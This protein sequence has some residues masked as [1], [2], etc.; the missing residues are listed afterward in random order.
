MTAEMTKPDLP[1]LVISQADRATYAFPPEPAA[2]TQSAGIEALEALAVTQPL[3][4]ADAELLVRRSDPHESTVH[5]FAAR[6][7]EQRVRLAIFALNGTAVFAAG[8]MLQIVLIRYAGMGHDLSYVIQTVVSVQVGFVLARFL[9]WRDRQVYLTVALVKYNLQMLAVTGLGIAGYAGLGRLGVNFIAANVGVTAVLTPVS[10]A[11]S[12]RW[13]LRARRKSPG[14]WTLVP[15]PLLLLLTVQA[16]LS[17]RLM[18]SNTAFSDEALYLWSGHLELTHLL[19]GVKVP[20]FQTY[21]S[22]APVIYPILGAIADS[23]GGL[24]GARLLSLCFMLGATALLYSTTRRLFSARAGA[25]AIAVFVA[26]GATQSLGAFATYDSMA[27]F[28]LALASW[29]TVRAQGWVSEPALLCSALVLAFADATKYATALWNPVVLALAVLTATRGGALRALSRGVRL[30]IYTAVSALVALYRLGGPTYIHG[31]MFTTVARQAGGT[32]ATWWTIVRN[33]SNWIGVLAILVGIAVC[34]SFTDTVRVRLLCAVLGGALFLAP[35]HQAQIHILTSLSKHIDFGAWF[36]A[37]AA[38]Y[39]LDR[40]VNV[41][42]RKGWRVPA[43]VAG[44]I[45]LGGL[46]QATQF[47]HGWPPAAQMTADLRPLVRS[48]GCPCLVAQ[49]NVAKYY[50]SGELLS[51]EITGPYSFYYWDPALHREIHGLSAYQQAIRNHYFHIIETDP[52][53][54]PSTFGAVAHALATTTGY[55]LVDVIPIPHWGADRIEIWRYE[56][57]TSAKVGEH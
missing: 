22:G 49:A 48:T 5:R 40:A 18:W 42:F 55:R 3:K 13:S 46:P 37:I 39:I 29:L 57:F 32:T 9:T 35:L 26:I 52:G 20:Q 15:W 10:F 50:L 36:G 34:V 8:L 23:Y 14:H 25:A 6:L 54:S 31:V 27:I 51:E 1:K 12:H 24:I 33:S 2:M 43:V 11:V 45:A 17:L 7:W 53:E 41:N 28:L 38:G 21:F 56:P 19:Y 16:G 44:I 47:F 4:V 30:L